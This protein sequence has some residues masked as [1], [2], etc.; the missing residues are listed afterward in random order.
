MPDETTTT[1]DSSQKLADASKVETGITPK[2]NPTSTKEMIDKAVNDALSAAGRSAKSLN[3]QQAKLD[4]QAADLT[5]K[6][7]AWQRQQEEAEEMA[8]AD[9]MP[10]LTALRTKRQ[11]EAE[12][13][14]RVTELT[15]RESKLAAREAEL[16]DIVKQHEILTRTQLAAEVAV[17]G[18]D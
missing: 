14:T 12:D 16:A 17:A 3:E 15:E 10:A 9:D 6:Q 11:K 1:E 7:M 5:A 8:V 2:E 4:K 13:K 18:R